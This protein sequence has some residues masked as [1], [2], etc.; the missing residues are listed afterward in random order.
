[1][2]E[3]NTRK[4]RK[5]ESEVEYRLACVVIIRR[6]A[7]VVK[8]IVRERLAD[9]AAVELKGEEHEADLK[10]IREAMAVWF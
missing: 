5:E 10:R 1:V 8:H 6:D 3:R 7:Q 2:T 4:L 9:V